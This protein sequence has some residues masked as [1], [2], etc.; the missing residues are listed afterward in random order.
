MKPKPAMWRRAL[1][2]AL[3]LFPLAGLYF[4]LKPDRL[5][6]PEGGSV[7][8]AAPAPRPEPTAIIDGP[9]AEAVASAG[10]EVPATY[11]APQTFVF[12]DS[13]SKRSFT[14]ALDQISIRDA[15]GKD[16]LRPLDPPATPESY[17]GRIR[18]L[19]G[20]GQV[21][22]V[23]Y[24]E[25]VTPTPYNRR[26]VTSSVLMEVPENV[27]RGSLA[28]ALHLAT[29]M[30][31]EGLPKHIVLKAASPLAALAGMDVWNS[32][33]SVK[34]A[35]VLLAKQQAKRAMPNDTLIANQWHLKATAKTGVVA[36]TDVNIESVWNYPSTTA[37]TY[38]RGSGISVGIVDDGLQTAHPDLSA[39][40]DT[41]NDKDWNGNDSDPNP[42]NGDDHG[43]SCA[44]NV[45]AR[46]NNNLGVSGTAPEATL[47]GMRLIAA[48][49]TDSQEAEAMSYLNNIIFVKSNSWGPSDDGSTLEAPGTLT[50]AA[51]Q[52]AVT[53]GRNNR[54][55]IF[56]WAGGNGAEEGDNS[57]YDGYANSIYT[58]AVG[59]TDSLGNRAYYSEPGANLIVSAPSSG[60]S[61]ALGI[62]TVDR[63]GSN[64]YNTGS[65]DGE[66]SDANY[67]QT[68]GGTSSATPTAAGVVALMLQRN[69]NLGWRDVQEILIRS[70]KKLKP[71]DSG[72]ANNGAGFHF[73][74]DFGGGLIDAAAAVTMAST[75]TNLAGQTSTAVTQSGLSVAIPNN[76]TTGI[77][78]TFAVSQNIRAEQVT[79]RLSINH[80]ARGNLAI[81]LTSPTGMV[82]RLTEVHSDTGD[83][84]SDWTF[85]SARHWGETASGTWT[86][87]IAD[88][89]STGNSTGG[90]LTAAELTVF[91][92]PGVPVN[93]PPTVQITSPAT[94]A[95]YSPGAT[96][97][98]TVTAS[99]LTVSGSTGVVSSVQILDNG[100]PVGSPRT[101]PPYTFTLT[102]SLGTHALVARA[103]DSEGASADSATV[104]ISLVNSPP[105]ITAATIGN[106]YA[107]DDIALT[108]S[109]VAA[110]DPDGTTPTIS[111]QW[112]SSANGVAFTD[113]AGLTSATLPADPSRSGL[114]W[115]CALT[116][117]DGSLSSAVFHTNAVNLLDRPVTSA[118]AGSAYSYQS[119]LVLAGGGAAV[120]RDAIINEFS[121]GPSGGTA[122]WVEIL[123]LRQAN[124]RNWV[125]RDTAGGSTGTVRFADSAVWGAIPAGTRIVIYNHV[126]KDTLL[127][128]AEDTDP[129]DRV[130][131]LASNNSTFFSTSVWPALGNSGDGLYLVNSDSQTVAQVGYGNSTISPNVGTV[132]GG[133][134]AYYGGDT[135]E[136]ADIAANWQTTISTSAR[137]LREVRALLPG[138][139]LSGGSYSQDFN[140]TPGASGTAYPDGW[141]S[142]SNASEDTAMTVGNSAST[143]GANYNYGSRI[144]L[145]GSGS[146]FD[147]GSIVLALANTNGLSGLKISFDVIKIRE[148]TR[149]NDFVLEYSLTSAT[150]SDFTAVTGGGY[151]SGS[152]TEGTVTTFSNIALPAAVENRSGPVYLRWRYATNSGGG[153]RD[154]IALDN[155][156]VS[157]G[158]TTP[159]LAVSVT[160]NTFS[161]AA[162][163]SAAT[164]T[165]SVS[166]AVASNLVITLTS[167]NTAEATVPA[168]VT[169]PAG[170]T[171]VTFAVTAVDDTELDGSQQVSITAAAA[172]YNSGAATI[173]VTDSET[174]LEGVTPG[175][176]NSAANTAWISSLVSGTAGN[177]AAFSLASGSTLPAGLT[178]D[179]QTGL[180]S[181]TIA[182]GVTGEFNIVIQRTNGAETVSQ[183]FTL[184]VT[185]GSGSTYASW[186]AGYPGLSNTSQTGDPDGD[187]LAN[188][189]EYYLGLAP[190]AANANA[191]TASRSGNVLSI[192]YPRS[193]SATGITAVVEWSDTLAAGFWSTAGVTTLVITPGSPTETVRSSISLTSADLKKF[194]RIKVT[195]P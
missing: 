91:G 64:G 66:L 138:V 189:V 191:I 86:L 33:G 47:V 195:A 71:T 27:D 70:A 116:A 123:V 67:T 99:D 57:N 169:I 49:T 45:A 84:Y 92:T 134:A 177:P 61:P 98:V 82:S 108:V 35:E 118:T 97:N 127:P 100:T 180:I 140:T 56:M 81:T 34:T 48:A 13:G 143:A 62:T 85:M 104:S 50:K 105:V 75:W 1:T 109:G 96:V 137:A 111:Y 52:Q 41:V 187:G 7:D 150:A 2:P 93:P 167:S 80:T 65:T 42:G 73:H 101:S 26:L 12:N 51:L 94:G 103:T 190:N 176:G 130:M 193:V 173:T 147:P 37:G 76:N 11:V 113:V 145:L 184:T 18:A 77:S 124:L 171:S 17:A 88:Q 25:G 59:A 63:S 135:D 21:M 32:L 9:D 163:A 125:F 29:E 185:A 6:L 170:Q 20:E 54:G 40:V 128:A 136:G 107:Y 90:T 19:E 152:I 23:L 83:N 148:Q 16:Q 114:K 5:S 149:S 174:P 55:T 183:S 38:Y 142:Y 89:S 22:P 36:G 141:T 115:R 119:G 4:G 120:T 3:F 157:T 133:R 74:H 72:W 164:G 43:T 78:R 162:G 68:F 110:S 155:V 182:A 79:V 15:D 46:G 129:S 14:L 87:K 168:T 106:A 132:S 8:S 153:S 24:P 194:L 156:V 161:E 39:N 30:V 139:T 166:A 181:G 175:A 192:T 178:L 95:V 10:R 188:L 160:P 131:V 60:D 122:E 154:G 102:P 53:T 144:G 112:Q 117:S 186:I 172:G 165:V 58:I 159:A 121:Q 126:S 44:G 179:A 151:L 69:P 146:A 31:P 158:S 28:G